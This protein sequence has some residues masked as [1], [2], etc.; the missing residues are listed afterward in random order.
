MVWYQK[1]EYAIY[2]WFHKATENMIGCVTYRPGC[3]SLFRMSSSKIENILKKYTAAKTDGK[4]YVQYDQGK[5]KS[6]I[7][8]YFSLSSYPCNNIVHITFHIA[9][10]DQLFS[11]ILLQEGCKVE[12]VAASDAKTFV[13]EG[14]SEF[15]NQRKE[16]YQSLI[17]N[18]VGR[19]KNWKTF[20]EKDENT[21]IL[22]IPYTSF[23]MM[24][25]ILTPGI[26][27]LMII[28][29][30]SMAFPSIPP[31]AIFSINVLLVIQFVLV[32]LVA[33][34]KIQ[35]SFVGISLYSGVYN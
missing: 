28:G 35:V 9:E 34:N 19:L 30:I 11:N 14:L 26:V 25:A 31:Y 18:Y 17:I 6:F 8:L 7:K 12:Y 1:F 10:G 32:C 22:Y 23:V 13:P 27:F 3:I 16:W 2:H 33:R 15:Y 29:S 4:D 21:S 5:K 20:T 24:Y